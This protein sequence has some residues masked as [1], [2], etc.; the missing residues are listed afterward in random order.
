M[1]TILCCIWIFC[2][3]L[4]YVLYRWAHRATNSRWTRND[5]L[6][7]IV[8]SIVYGPLAPAMIV[9]AFLLHKMMI[10]EWG[11]QEAKW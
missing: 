8:F 2:A 10:S 9:V 11:N 4:G 6:Y 7:A 5:R 1:I 3:P